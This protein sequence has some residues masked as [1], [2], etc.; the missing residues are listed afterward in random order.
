MAFQAIV[1]A[2]PLF[3]IVAPLQQDGCPVIGI[4]SKE[5]YE[6]EAK[7]NKEHL[8]AEENC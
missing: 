3:V 6:K 5:Y 7:E 8:H 1:D 2:H 4:D